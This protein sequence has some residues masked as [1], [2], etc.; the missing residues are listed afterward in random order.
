MAGDTTIL[1]Q[2][3][4]LDPGGQYHQ[5]T[6][7]VSVSPG[8]VL[9]ILES[10]FD[11][12]TGNE[13]LI[14]A[15]GSFI[16]PGWVDAGTTMQ[17]P[18][19][20]WKE[21]AVAHARAAQLGG[22]TSLLPYPCLD[23]VPENGEMIRGLKA[24]LNDMPVHMFPI[25]AA[26]EHLEG[27]EMA[28][29]YDMY[30]AGTMVFSDGPLSFPKADT[31]LRIL[32][33]ISAFQGLLM[34]GA[35]SP[36][37]AR[38]GQMHEG[39]S[40]TSLGLPGIP[41]VAEVIAVERDL[42]LLRY[43]GKGK[44][45][46]GP[47]SVPRAIEMVASAAEEGLDVTTSVCVNHFRFTD[48]DLLGFDENLKVIP[49]FRSQDDQNRL[50]SLLKEGKISMLTTGHQAEGIEEKQVEFSQAMPGMLSLQT[51]FS[52]AVDSLIAPGHI[53]PE[54]WVRLI[55]TN[56]RKRFFLDPAEIV[57]GSAEWTWFTP[58][59]TTHI[60]KASI[61]S[62]AKNSPFLDQR[63]PGK[64]LGCASKGHLYLNQG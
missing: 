60:T 5:Q 15:A 35:V 37:W 4:I 52:S 19:A 58:S 11:R 64:V 10:P 62:R 2:V 41:S 39:V 43:A 53:T 6:V 51:A 14:P 3:R 25:G 34:T 54:S 7:D 33:Y 12:T 63:L 40:S 48:D 45:H 49:P 56:P 13:I 18:G 31:L 17:D 42:N 26:S 1:Q 9:E 57:N 28:G 46:F 50:V 29:L 47:L 21:T 36:E 32:T 22:F 27:E 55:S 23:P 44:M 61:P 16:S 24:R 59:G 38:S 8:G 30:Q 20:E